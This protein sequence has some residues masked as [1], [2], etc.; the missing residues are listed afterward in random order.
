MSI[1]FHQSVSVFPGVRLHFSGHGVSVSVG[2]P[3]AGVNLGPQ[4]A[5]LH[6][7]VP[8]TGLSYRHRLSGPAEPP[9]GPTWSEP[10]P[11]PQPG[12]AVLTPLAGEIRSAH[13][14]QLTSPDLA[15]L[16]AL[17]NA[18]S[19][20][21]RELTAALPRAVAARNV[22]W[23]EFERARQF[24]LLLL[25]RAK[26]PKL[27]QAFEEAKSALE[28]RAKEF[29]GCHVRVDFALDEAAAEAYRG[30]LE[31]HTRLRHSHR[32]WDV[33][34]SVATDRVVQRTIASSTI[35]RT[36]VSLGAARDGIVSSRWPGLLFGN[37]NGEPLEIYPGFC[38][39]RDSRTQADFALIDLRELRVEFSSVRF[40]ED[41]TVPGDAQ[42]VGQTW[43]KTNKDGSPDRRFAFNRQIPICRYGELTFTS[44]GGVREAY[45]ASDHDA[46]QAFAAAYQRL[47]AALVDLMRRDG[48]G[49]D[50][51]PAP[52]TTPDPG[53][54]FEIPRLPHV[55][56]AHGYTVAGA[57]ALSV[58]LAATAWFGTAHIGRNPWVS[59]GAYL[60]IRA[61]PAL[62]APAAPVSAAPGSAAAAKLA[63][64]PVP[65]AISPTPVEGE[66]VTAKQGANVRSGANG[67]APV[68]RTVPQGA[69]MRVHARQGGWVQ[70]GDAQPWGW[71]HSSLLDPAH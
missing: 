26:L 32:L 18:A 4:G 16:K 15:G 11:A 17:V 33:T 55:P 36:P 30:L 53:E 8:G 27:Q 64:T 20:R 52:V 40:V 45:Q 13:V 50:A 35:T 31:A 37:A 41:E 62:A 34:S 46:T 2:A 63:A 23:H 12:A 21:R 19:H 29:D 48:S 3:G 66:R 1:G 43:A 10:G 51:E 61:A 38:L 44:P 70:V 25:S 7:G 65:P 28:E 49:A 69:V 57:A 47:Q 54:R 39:V 6:L 60:P 59:P 71:I 9:K 56:P 42:V 14:Q 24:P 68:I 22:A 5:R 67:T 58:V